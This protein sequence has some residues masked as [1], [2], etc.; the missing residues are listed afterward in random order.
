MNIKTRKQADEEGKIKDSL[1]IRLTGPDGKLKAKYD[2]EKF[3]W[4][5]ILLAIILFIPYVLYRIFVPRNK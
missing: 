5:E 2:S 3:K 1:S 4:Y